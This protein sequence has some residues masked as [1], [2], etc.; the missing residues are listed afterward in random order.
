MN[1]MTLLAVAAAGVLLLAVFFGTQLFENAQ[2]STVLETPVAAEAEVKTAAVAANALQTE[3][4]I[5]TIEITLDNF[6]FEGPAG[7]SGALGKNGAFE[8]PEVVLRLKNNEPVHLVFKNASNIVTHQVISP[9]FAM[10]EEQV[11][12]LG[13]LETLELDYTPRFRDVEDG[14]TLVFNLTCHERHRQA[15]DHYALGMRAL[16]EIVP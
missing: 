1:P 11:Y 9:I 2:P 5:K 7:R 4:N 16:I 12:V 10:P 14:E 6:F 15:T 3:E 13:P 8:V